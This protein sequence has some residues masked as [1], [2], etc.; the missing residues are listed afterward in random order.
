MLVF[1]GP[2][3]SVLMAHEHRKQE[4]PPFAGPP[5]LNVDPF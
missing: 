5:E 1:R 4:K 3:R 2:E